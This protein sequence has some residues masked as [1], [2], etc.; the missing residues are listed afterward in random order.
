MIYVCNRKVVKIFLFYFS[1]L[2][3]YWQVCRV[4]PAHLLATCPATGR[5]SASDLLTCWLPAQLMSGVPRLTCSP[6]GHLPGYWQVCRVWPAHMLATCP[7][8][9]WRYAQRNKLTRWRPAQCPATVMN[10][11]CSLLT[12]RLPTWSATGDVPRGTSSPSGY[13]KS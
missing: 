2:P 6:A 13:L 12:W 8:M 1:D 3:S 9:Y 5:C 11:N 7:A 4:W 10:P